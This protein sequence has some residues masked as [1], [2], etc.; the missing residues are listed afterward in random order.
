M[1]PG[2]LFPKNEKFYEYGRFYCSCLL[3]FIICGNGRGV[4]LLLGYSE[5][6][7]KKRRR[8]FGSIHTVVHM[9]NVK[10]FGIFSLVF[11]I[12]E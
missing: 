3:Y 11:F 12:G 10:L 6:H 8:V 5:M 9:K 7:N 2:Y 4:L 1:K